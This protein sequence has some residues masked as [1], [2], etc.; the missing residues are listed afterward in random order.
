[1]TYDTNE[2]HV[3]NVWVDNVWASVWILTWYSVGGSEIVIAWKC[4][5]ET[6]TTYLY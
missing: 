4:L 5:L 1:M 6:L 3:P 2:W